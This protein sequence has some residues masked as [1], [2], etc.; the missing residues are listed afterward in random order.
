[1]PFWCAAAVLL[2]PAIAVA[3]V[4]REPPA[5]AVL[6]LSATAVATDRPLDNAVAVLL[7]FAIAVATD[8]PEYAVAVLLLVAKAKLLA[9]SFSLALWAVA[10]LLLNAMARLGPGVE[11]A[12]LLPNCTSVFPPAEIA[13]PPLV[14]CC[15]VLAPV[16]G[17]LAPV[18]GELAPVDGVA[19]AVGA[20]TPSARSG[21][22]THTVTN[23]T[24]VLIGT[25]PFSPPAEHGN[26]RTLHVCQDYSSKFAEYL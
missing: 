19:H 1:V 11:V 6:L 20:P 16:D 22:P 9:K 26:V 2:L 3:W 21:V 15:V 13:M 10:L 4:N 12:V 5:V 25:F 8:V 7:L 17:V 23:L 18:D 14:V 24:D